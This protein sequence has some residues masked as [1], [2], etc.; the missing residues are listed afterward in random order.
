MERRDHIKNLHDKLNSKSV[1]SDFDSLWDELEPRLPKKKKRKYGMILIPIFLVGIGIL[2]WKTLGNHYDNKEA[3]FDKGFV[4]IDDD[5]IENELAPIGL[6]N[7][8][9]SDNKP[10]LN[11]DINSNVDTYHYAQIEHAEINKKHTK[12]LNNHAHTINPVNKIDQIN[13]S[14]QTN[15]GRHLNIDERVDSNGEIFK[16]TQTNK[17]EQRDV[18]K[19]AY[20]NRSSINTEVIIEEA[21]SYSNT[22]S[23]N[24]NDER[25]FQSDIAETI[26][27]QKN[28]TA[29]NNLHSKAIGSPRGSGQLVVGKLII[30]TLDRGI[31]SLLEF[32]GTLLSTQPKIAEAGKALNTK[33]KVSVETYLLA[34]F[35]QK[36]QDNLSVYG[37]TIDDLTS[38]K[39]GYTFGTTMS[40]SHQSGI[41]AGLGIENTKAIEK[42]RVNNVLSSIE[43]KINE[44]A[45]SLNGAFISR[46]AEFTKTIKQDALVY[47]S[48][49]QI[50]M[51]PFIGYTKSAKINYSISAAPL[52][53]VS[54]RYEG[55]L[56]DEADKITT[57]I[58]QLYESSK[59]E[60]N[61]FLLTGI[62]SVRV[63]K[64]LDLGIRSQL[65]KTRNVAS[66]SNIHFRSRLNSYSFGLNLRYR[67]Y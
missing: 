12:N 66:D 40:L 43:D 3:K 15:V 9:K 16:N 13:R 52:L 2:A 49:T 38:I 34:D 39:I 61:G 8:I 64:G 36:F 42:F 50:N 29:D 7:A 56:I 28:K 41:M 31:I 22:R 63:W 5:I 6:D 1:I 51:T 55:Y 48:Y 47:N 32:S 27:R 11:S 17:Y 21:V 14:N 58:S 26:I 60:Y 57:D 25:L 62:A 54:R 35:N 37:Q 53:N 23:S 44:Q 24:L 18:V 4:I 67:L 10:I 59:L 45:F 33:Y 30:P 65:R 20:N 19:Q 46:E